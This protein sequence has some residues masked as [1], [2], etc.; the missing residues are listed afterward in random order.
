MTNPIDAFFDK[1]MAKTK[2]DIRKAKLEIEQD[3]IK[4]QESLDPTQ[5]V[6]TTHRGKRHVDMRHMALPQIRQWA[7]ALNYDNYMKYKNMP[8]ILPNGIKSKDDVL[9]VMNPPAKRDV[10][11]KHSLTIEKTSITDMFKGMIGMKV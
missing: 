11:A 2:A 3:K 7:Q 8:F 10:N 6:I 1:E 4:H 5:P 9:R